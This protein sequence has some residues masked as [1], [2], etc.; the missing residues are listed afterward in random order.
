MSVVSL[1]GLILVKMLQDITPACGN[2]RL[3]ESRNNSLDESSSVG[4]VGRLS[5][6]ATVC[7]GFAG[8]NYSINL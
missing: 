6:A 8:G 1:G 5:A 7:A 4:F 3:T 2:E